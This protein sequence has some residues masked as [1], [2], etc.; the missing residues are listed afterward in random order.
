MI[1][2]LPDFEVFP[3]SRRKIVSA[4]ITAGLQVEAA[5]EAVLQLMSPHSSS[6]PLP[7]NSPLLERRAPQETEPQEGKSKQATLL[8]NFVK[9]NLIYIINKI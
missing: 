9:L 6:K 5:A 8:G 4:A 2:N 7:Q 1:E 3:E